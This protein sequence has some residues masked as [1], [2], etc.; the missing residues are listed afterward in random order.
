M[1]RISSPDNEHV[2]R[3]T[4]LQRSPRRRLSDGL[5]VVEGLRLTR[6]LTASTLPIAEAF[7]TVEFAE[8]HSGQQVLA[9]LEKRGP[10]YLVPAD[11]L[12]RMSDTESPQGILVVL[13]IPSLAVPEAL[14]FCLVLDGLREPGNVGAVLRTAW[15][16]GVPLVLLAPGTA[17]A[18]NPKA[19]RAAMGAHF[20]VPIWRA[21]WD[22]IG[23]LLGSRVIW[24]AEAAGAIPYYRVDWTGNTALI[25][26]GEASGAASEARALA[27]GRLV[28]IPMVPGVDSLNVGAAAA[29]LLCE[30]ARQQTLPA[31]AA[32]R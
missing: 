26:G 4:A 12:E 13:S 32:A 20:H 25:I 2:R 22:K 9:E 7:C 3:V 5:M 15:A 19:V 18:T 24:L 1:L 10:C 23:D 21:P 30:V 16:V 6:E 8:S 14:P 31:C 27:R 28:T 11:L 17:D 29:V